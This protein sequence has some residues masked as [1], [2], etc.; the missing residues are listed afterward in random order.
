[1]TF[2][3]INDDEIIRIGLEVLKIEIKALQNLCQWINDDF[4]K[5]C[6]ILFNCKGKVVVTG[7]GKSGHIGRKI[8]ATF[9][10]TGTPAFF[11]HPAEALHGDLGMI[12]AEDVV[13]AL[14]N[15]GE[16]QEI[17]AILPRIKRLKSPLLS[18]T[19]PNSS[20]AKL[21]DINLNVSVTQEA[22]PMGLAP[23]ASTTAAL[24]MGDALAIA[25]LQTKGFTADDFALSHPGGRLGRRLLL[26]VDDLMH[27][28]SEMPQVYE[29]ALLKDAL[30]EMTNKRLGMTTIVAKE[31]PKMILGVFTDG[32][33]RRYFQKN[34]AIENTFIKDVMHRQFIFAQSG[35]LAI[36]I[37]N[38][39]EKNQITN[40]PVLND[41]SELVGVIH[42]HD[43]FKA[44]VM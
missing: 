10:S 30:I 1:M 37:V 39:L 43:L 12:T 34:Q 14:S 19:A 3:N 22:C 21:A 6:H 16:T 35:M 33:L 18:L 11:I 38:L 29:D 5:A 31:N 15:S 40:L 24:A 17:L 2:M 13:L 42:I 9:A 36:D 25:L 7:I 8:A 20:L 44:G 26:K 4:I 23:T 28:G 27:T 32:D 41:K